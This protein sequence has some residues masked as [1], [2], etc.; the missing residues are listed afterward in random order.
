MS[1]VN[2]LEYSRVWGHFADDRN[3]MIQIGNNKFA[4]HGSIERVVEEKLEAAER[5]FQ[6]L[7]IKRSDHGLEIG[8]G[9]GIHTA[10]CADRTTVSTQSRMG[11]PGISTAFA[12]I[13][14]TL[15]AL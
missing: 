11:S 4:E 15:H 13:G 1:A 10:F 14:S 3:T 6:H 8:S 9:P 12:A 2:E 7:A 5:I